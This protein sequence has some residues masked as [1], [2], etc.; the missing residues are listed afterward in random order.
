MV[1]TEKP[2][3]KV[4][5]TRP[6]RPDG[7]EKV[8][9]RAE[10]GA[11][12]SLPGLLPGAVLRSPHAHARI[13]SIDTS[14]AEAMAGV[15]A[16]VTSADFP[17]REGDGP[18]A[19][20]NVLAHDK[21]LYVGHA[22]AAVAAVDLHT[23]E[24][25]V[26]LIE[27]QYEVLPHVMDVR[28]AMLD[29]APILDATLRTGEPDGSKGDSATNVAQ[30]IHYEKGDLAAGFAEADIVIEREYETT[31]AHQGYIEPQNGTALWG[32]D[33]QIRIWT[34]TQGLFAVRDTV[35]GMLGLPVKSVKVE[36]VEIGG[37]FG[38]KIPTYLPPVAAL[39][40]RK[41]GKP[42][43]LTMSRKEVLEA[44]GP[45][46]GTYMRVKMGAK[47]DGTLTAMEA[48]LAFEAGGYPGSPVGAATMC[49][50]AP[51]ACANQVIDGYDVLV[52]KPQ[53]AAYRAPGAPASEYAAECLIDE[54]A[55]ALDRDP[56][57]L[58]L[59]NSVKEGDSRADGF[60]YGPVGHVE[61]L[62]EAQESPHYQSELSGENRGRGVASGFWFNIGFE[63][64][65]AAQIQSD[66]TVPLVMGAVDIGGSRAS[67]AMQFA[68]TLGIASE[69][70]KPHI[71]DTDSVGFTFLTGGSRTA[72]A[73]GWAAYEC[74]M[75]MRRQMEERAATIWDCDRES[76]RYDDDGVI[77]GPAAAA[78]APQE[79][80]FKELAAELPNTGG[81]IVGRA[82]VSKTTHGPAFATHIVDVEVDAETGKVEVLRYTAIQ[83]V[84]TAIHPSYVEGQMQG[85]AAQGIGMALNEEYIWDDKGRMVNSSL[86][87][88]RMPTALDLPMLDTIIVEV[89]NPGHPYGVRGV[90]E[91]PIIPPAPALHAAIY[92]AIGERM[93]TLP[94]SPR[95][96]LERTLPDD[97]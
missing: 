91:V 21:V 64:S 10:Y 42:V 53:T 97:E 59:Q 69:D 92:N 14:K 51:Y 40:S 36:P 57:E 62:Q 34:S 7:V 70:I 27:V 38:G 83:D 30:H 50:F 76:V 94:M 93:R 85:G 80:T 72:F 45:T 66:G 35:A 81:G 4:V 5:G 8:N 84:G 73:N 12:V 43:K 39:L 86:L 63:T 9:G 6:I 67:A 41:S 95:R 87:D 1:T 68:E 61:C 82:D 75:D 96:I 47:K 32:P 24:D 18:Q 31:M 11:D 56:L 65:M 46:S 20:D 19:R 89:P 29:G 3:Y 13:L 54:I 71:V 33:D 44:T 90:G 23:A 28:D 49:V 60:T 25:A 2:K 22:V 55:E 77:R 52:N 74:A 79:F 78:G 15:R 16:V 58:R 26:E 17:P 88:Y 37:G 48:W